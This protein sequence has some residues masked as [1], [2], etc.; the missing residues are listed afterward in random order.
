MYTFVSLKTEEEYK[1][2]GKKES[3]FAGVLLLLIALTD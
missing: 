2:E 3:A 1:E